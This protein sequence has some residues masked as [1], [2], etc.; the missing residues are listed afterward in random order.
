MNWVAVGPIN[1]IAVGAVAEAIG[2][3]G[4]LVSLVY[5]AIQIRQN[6]RLM[7]RSV[8]SAELRRSNAISSPAMVFA[9]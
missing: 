5:V 9:S 2:A 8:Q 1:W 4:V 6:T 7:L 3:T